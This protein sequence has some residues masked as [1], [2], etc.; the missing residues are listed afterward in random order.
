VV[1]LLAGCLVALV[2]LRTVARDTQAQLA[3]VNVHLALLQQQLTLQ[4]LQAQQQQ[5]G[6]P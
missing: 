1:A 3:V 4:T 6:Q 5:E 2:S